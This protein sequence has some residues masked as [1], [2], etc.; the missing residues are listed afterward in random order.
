M[1]K[2]SYIF[3]LI[4]FIL[5]IGGI[6][7]GIVIGIQTPKRAPLKPFA[8]LEKIK[9]MHELHLVTYNYEEMIVIGVPN[10][11]K[12]INGEVD[13]LGTLSIALRDSVIADSNR[14]VAN[15]QAL[16]WVE[17]A[18]AQAQVTRDSARKA[19]QDKWI[20]LFGIKKKNWRTSPENLAWIAAKQ[21]VDNLKAFEKKNSRAT[22]PL[23]RKLKNS[24]RSLKRVLRDYKLAK[25]R[26]DEKDQTLLNNAELVIVAPTSINGFINMGEIS[27]KEY[28]FDISGL[29]DYLTLLK[30]SLSEIQGQPIP[31]SLKKAADSIAVA[32]TPPPP[33]VQDSTIIT[34][35][36]ISE[37]A[38]QE[39]QDSSKLQVARPIEA[40]IN[41]PIP[42]DTVIK[43]H[44]VRLIDS[45]E[46]IKP[47]DTLEIYLPHPSA[48]QVIVDLDTTKKIDLSSR[49]EISKN[50]N[51][52]DVFKHLRDEL[53]LVKQEVREKALDQ[54]LLTETRKLAE[55][56]V[57][58]L[59]ASFKEY[60][61]H[62]IRVVFEE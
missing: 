51:Y 44:L 15:Q 20:R 33:S 10:K 9:Y 41:H 62:V 43:A 6:I 31:D 27:F 7:A 13:T 58:K 56:Y 57:L 34:M 59:I 32:A 37:N 14:L 39:A 17:N 18:L 53:V 61:N 40:F 36:S 12:K 21:K 30:D 42:T 52:F 22:K 16:T 26:R 35:R 47:Q 2:D 11:I 29:D 25:D 46:Q 23:E 45:L 8:G 28:P 24:Q 54:G 1:A 19:F 5:L 60:D 48:G 4:A 38:S 55:D 50:H 3:R 49:F